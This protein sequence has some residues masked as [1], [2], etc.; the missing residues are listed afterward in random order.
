[1]DREVALA[2]VGLAQ[3]ALVWSSLRLLFPQQP[4][5]Q[6]VGTL[7]ISLLP[8]HL[9]LAQQVTNAPLAATLATAAGSISVVSSR[10]SSA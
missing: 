1:M 9:Y 5:R 10:C 7:L 3:V 4:R 2:L 6:L 8:M